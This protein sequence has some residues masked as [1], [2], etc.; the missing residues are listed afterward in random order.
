M[1]KIIHCGDIH[2]DTPFSARFTS[3]ESEIRRAEISETFSKVIDMAKNADLLLIAGDL[4]DSE[5]PSE[6]TVKF[7]IRKF[8]EIGNIPVFIVAGNHDPYTETS[9]YSNYN[10][11]DNVYVFGGELSCVELKSL[12]LRIYGSSFTEKYCE[13]SQLKNVLCDP[14]FDNILLMHGDANKIKSVYNPIYTEFFGEC[15]FKYAALGH[16]HK[17]DGIKKSGKTKYAYCGAMEGR[18]FD[19]LGEKGVIEIEID[20]GVLE[21]RFVPV[22]KRKFRI[23]DVDITDAAD[24]N[25]VVERIFNELENNSENSGFEKDYIR[26]I[27]KGTRSEKFNV[28]YDT[29]KEFLD[30]KLYYAELLD[31]SRTSVDYTSFLDENSLKGLFSRIMQEKIQ[32]SSSDEE[33]ETARLALKL[34]IDA[35]LDQEYN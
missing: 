5:N 26:V 19:E 28:N 13:E 23:L 24:N 12:N 14:S 6:E 22:C 21:A 29:V 17:F 32:N 25:E 10:F 34:G 35:M 20:N 8:K 33:R 7:V 1:V 16:I 27:L 4:F 2:F 18:G 15:G 3:R 11:G 31:E 9:V 30:E